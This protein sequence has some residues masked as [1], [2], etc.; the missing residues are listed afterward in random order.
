MT[1][2]AVLPRLG[3]IIIDRHH[4]CHLL[5]WKRLLHLNQDPVPTRRR[6][7]LRRSDSS[8][9][10]RYWYIHNGI[11][12]RMIFIRITML[13]RLDLLGH[14]EIMDFVKSLLDGIATLIA[15]LTACRC[16]VQQPGKTKSGRNYCAIAVSG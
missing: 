2:G 3:R 15:I 8:H 10:Q 12:I 11:S 7:E 6:R 14:F 16:T 13:D 1:E 9:R 5:G 4:A